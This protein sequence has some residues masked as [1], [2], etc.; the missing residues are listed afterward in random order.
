MFNKQNVNFGG[1]YF[2]EYN[3]TEKVLYP[4]L[5]KNYI[6]N[7]FLLSEAFKNQ[8]TQSN[9]KINVTAIVG[10]NGSGKT[11]LLDCIRGILKGDVQG[12]EFIL[13]FLEN[14]EY[15]LVHNKSEEIIIDKFD[16]KLLPYYY[17]LI[18]MKSAFVSTIFD[19][20]IEHGNHR[21]LNLSTNYLLN[22]LNRGSYETDKIRRN[23]TFLIAK[24][25]K[26]VNDKNSVFINNEVALGSEGL[27]INLRDTSWIYNNEEIENRTHLNPDVTPFEDQ[28]R[29]IVASNELTLFK[30]NLLMDISMYILEN[31]KN[32]KELRGPK[33]A[34]AFQMQ[35]YINI[36]NP[37]RRIKSVDDIQEINEAFS[38]IIKS[39]KGYKNFVRKLKDIKNVLEF[40]FNH[41]TEDNLLT[42]ESI[43]LKKS[44]EIFEFLNKYNRSI[45]NGEYFNFSWRRLSTGEETIID[46][47]SRIYQ[48]SKKVKSRMWGDSIVLIIDELESNL[49]PFWQKHI[50][51][52][53]LSLIEEGFSSKSVHLIITSHSPF[54]I[55]ELPHNNVVLLEKMNSKSVIQNHIE[56]LELTFAANIHTILAHN[57]FLKDGVLGEFARGKINGLYNF[58]LNEDI[59][60]LK[61]YKED[62]EKLIYIISEP[63]IRN[64]ILSVWSSKMKLN[65]YDEIEELKKR[66]A[67]L[68]KGE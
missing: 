66:I 52:A 3:E 12:I 37:L 38:D 22:N 24:N 63:L 6:E 39:F 59:S 13:V 50:L 67:I 42:E 55:S 61:K 44:N 40:L 28:L 20:K 62:I 16:Y 19:R 9:C 7:F 68:E 15:T 54:V 29:K 48:I 43:V 35:E 25:L 46:I 11:T 47:F 10:E 2:F 49:H 27:E 31:A 14:D 33:N 57:F 26:F 65:V 8:P 4:R 58:I 17:F 41:V 56:D 32:W 51:K 53:L 18:K 23:L 5:N 64:K 34:R 36:I 21:E 30:K 60:T 45:I 1:K